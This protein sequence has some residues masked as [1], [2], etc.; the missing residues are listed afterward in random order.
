MLV[1]LPFPDPRF[2]CGC[3][4]WMGLLDS[5]GL[6]NHALL[7]LG[8]IGPAA[9]TAAHGVLGA[10]GDGVHLSAVHDPAFVFQSG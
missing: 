1:M 2:W 9:A 5:E 4:A 8:L 6:I 3:S 10:A 7:G